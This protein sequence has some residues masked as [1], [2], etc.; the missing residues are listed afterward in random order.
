MHR[1]LDDPRVWGPVAS[2][3]GDDFT[4]TSGDGK[5]YAGDT[6]WHSDG[7]GSRQ[8]MGMG[9]SIKTAFYLDKLTTLGFDQHTDVRRVE[10]ELTKQNLVCQL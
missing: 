4:Y 9:L 8:E 2:P 6:S 3:C 7:Y 1:L 10:P 5:Y